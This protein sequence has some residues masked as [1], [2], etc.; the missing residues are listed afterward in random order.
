[1]GESNFNGFWECKLFPLPLQSCPSQSSFPCLCPHLISFTPVSLCPHLSVCPPPFFI[2][3]NYTFQWS[4][5]KGEPPRF[6]TDKSAL[7]AAQ[8][9]NQG[10][11]HAQWDK[12]NDRKVKRGRGG[13][14]PSQVA[15]Y[16]MLGSM[17]WVN[18]WTGKDVQ[19]Y[20][21]TGTTTSPLTTHLSGYLP[22]EAFFKSTNE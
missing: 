5:T 22:C 14:L 6:L 8:L 10:A 4:L 15:G 11:L 21:T 12:V 2:P 1:M 18:P 3:Q 9:V 13:D 17:C 16:V 20:C 7:V 19:K